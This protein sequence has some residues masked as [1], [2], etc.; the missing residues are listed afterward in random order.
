MFS[1]NIM[2]GGNSDTLR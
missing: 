1:G 2:L